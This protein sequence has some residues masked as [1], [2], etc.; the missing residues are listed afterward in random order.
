MALAARAYAALEGLSQVTAAQVAAV[1]PMALQH[2]RS[3][4][5]DGGQMRWTESD[6]AT[7]AEIVAQNK[8]DG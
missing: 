8:D 7:V 4:G 6:D 1:A 5:A 2:R 3:L